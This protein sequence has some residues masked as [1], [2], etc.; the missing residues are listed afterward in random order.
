[1]VRPAA[2]LVVACMACMAC[3]LAAPTVA[4]AGQRT[5]AR[6]PVRGPAAAPAA[7]FSAEQPGST[8]AA[9]QTRED[10][11]RVLEQ[12]P[13]SLGH[14]LRL[15]PTLLDNPDYL[16]P[17]PALGAFVAQHPEIAH[18]PAYFFDRYGEQTSRPLDPQD[19]AF[20]MWNKVLEG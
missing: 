11:Q 19:R 15:D 9:R 16:Q 20:S 3:A 2:A 12:Y 5:S 7:P 6:E 10:L 8:Q 13:P 14:V 4:S 1:M 17:Y 18:N